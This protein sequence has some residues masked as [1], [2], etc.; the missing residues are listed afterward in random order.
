MSGSL[1]DGFLAA[2][3]SGHSRK[4]S[5]DRSIQGLSDSDGP[6]PGTPRTP[7]AA[8]NLT[9]TEVRSK[10]KRDRARSAFHTFLNRGSKMDRPIPAGDAELS[11]HYTQQQ[12]QPAKTAARANRRATSPLAGILLSRGAK[13]GLSRQEIAQL[14][15]LAEDQLD[16]ASDLGNSTRQDIEAQRGSIAASD[17]H[18]REE[19]AEVVITHYVDFIAASQGVGKLEGQTQQVRALLANNI[20]LLSSLKEVAFP[21]QEPAPESPTGDGRA[22]LDPAAAW[23]STPAGTQWREE[24]EALGDCLQEQ[25]LPEAAQAYSRLQRFTD[26][27]KGGGRNADGQVQACIADLA[28]H[29]TGLLTLAE[30]VLTQ[31]PL[32][33]TRSRHALAA[34]VLAGGKAMAAQMLLRAHSNALTRQQRRELELGGGKAEVIE[35]A[36]ALG[37]ATFRAIAGAADDVA[38]VLDGCEPAAR[39]IFMVWAMRETE[40]C[41]NQLAAQISKAQV[42]AAGLVP[43]AQACTL[44]MTHARGLQASHHLTLAPRLLKTLWPAFLEALVWC[45]GAATEAAR[46]QVGAEVDCLALGAPVQGARD[47][48]GWGQHLLPFRSAGDLLTELQGM[49]TALLPLAGPRAAQAMRQRSTALFA[50][51]TEAMQKAFQKHKDVRGVLPAPLE[52]CAQHK[53]AAEALPLKVAAEVSKL[54]DGTWK[55]AG[56]GDLPFHSSTDVVNAV[57][58]SLAELAPFAGPEAAQAM[59][60]ATTTLFKIWIE[61]MDTCFSKHKDASGELTPKLDDVA[62]SVVDLAVNLVDQELVAATQ[63]LAAACGLALLETER[64]NEMLDNFA[65][66]LGL[67]PTE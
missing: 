22:S 49:C 9:T 40:S 34:I 59:Q 11:Q 47:A 39:S 4:G 55:P 50:G 21:P 54:L 62:E 19:L 48:Q 63:P 26:P 3:R 42:P 27:S 51:Y 24:L 6:M 33:S 45:Q 16:L 20:A 13:Q 64:L 28:E 57:K 5:D 52:S 37:R 15:G 32:G 61:A 36:G 66:A 18:C 30:G 17:A 38:G 7:K 41:G 46:A 65:D 10:G 29:Q 25:R 53:A 14:A 31:C 23:R 60:K 12:M 67:H 58:A 1:D 8:V 44:A 35:Y 56:E 43:L 2:R